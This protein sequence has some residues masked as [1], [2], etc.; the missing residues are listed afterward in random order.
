MLVAS[1]SAVLLLADLFD[2]GPMR[3]PAVCVCVSNNG[4][5]DLPSLRETP[6]SPWEEDFPFGRRR[7]NLRHRQDG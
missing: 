2:K 5:K 4:F 1:G 3:A 7:L 6:K